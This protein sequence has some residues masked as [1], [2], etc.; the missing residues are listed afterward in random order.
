MY[1]SLKSLANLA[2]MCSVFWQEGREGKFK[3]LGFA[4]CSNVNQLQ[5]DHF[6][7]PR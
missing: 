6:M 3:S 4:H 7:F 5:V 2:V 1:C